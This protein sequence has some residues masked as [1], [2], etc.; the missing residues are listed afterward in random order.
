MTAI[1][2][3]LA[4]QILDSRGNPTVEVDVYLEDGAMG[5]AAVPS[6]AST[7][8]HEA[9]EL[10][11]GVAGAYKGKGVLKAVDAV[12]SEILDALAGMD[13]EDQV[14][15]DQAMIDLDGTPNKARLG[16]NAI[17]GVSLAVAKAAAISCGL[18]LYRYV[19]GTQARTLP[20]PMMNIV[21]G[22]A[23][24]DNPIDFQEFMVMPVGAPSLAEAVRVGSEIFHTLKSELKHAGHNTNVGDEGGFAPNLPSAEA[25]LDFVMKAIEKAGYKPGDDVVLALDCAATEFFKDG[26]YVYEGEGN[27][28]RSPHEQ[29]AYLAKLVADYPIRSIEDGMSEDDW[30]GW[31]ALTRE[32][33]DRCQLV[34]DDLFVTNVTRLSR[35]IAEGVG[36]SILVKVNQIGSL[37]ETLA[38][39][40]MA[41]RA[42]YTAVMSHRS[43]ETEDATIADLA[44]ATN[45]GQIKTGS[46]ARSDRTAKYNQLIR[47]EEELGT[48]AIY[49]GRGA[50]KGR[51]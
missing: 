20:V 12:N 22:G 34:G 30:E 5:R 27:K 39:V 13:A 44:V 25:A 3:I 42:S 23:H 49:A 17:L 7:G 40:D 32:V 45:C 24:A 1:A 16:A 6:G 35:G 28:R 38:A 47:I 36:N 51:L 46:L 33:G 8:A 2:N 48:S 11:D 41:H 31:A 29:A 43:G 14:A 26:A 18:P 10:R 50:L 15:V 9:V 37:T 19:G 21:N 4:R